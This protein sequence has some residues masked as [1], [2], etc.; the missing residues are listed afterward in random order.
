[1]LLKFTTAAL[2]AIVLLGR[3]GA[4]QTIDEQLQKAIY[5][6]ETAGNLD[7]AI[8][9][10]RQIAASRL[11]SRAVAAEAH[12]RLAKALLDKGDRDGAAREL[13]NLRANFGEYRDVIARLAP[14]LVALEL[15][16]RAQFGTAPDYT[17]YRHTATGTELTHAFG[18]SFLGDSESPDGGH[19]AVFGGHRLSVSVW[20]RPESID[21][22]SLE[23][24][25][26]RDVQLTTFQRQQF[27]GW[28]IRQQTIRAGGGPDRQ[29]ITAIAEY[30]DQ[31]RKMVE[32]L[33]WYRTTKTRVV[34]FTRLPEEDLGEQQPNFSRMVGA[35]VIP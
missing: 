33:T 15:R 8:P 13:Q 3:A 4:G 25:V 18:T 27:E 34:F 30:T 5:A 20:L 26:R 28:N 10:L 11:A 17:H 29:W 14:Q 2:A 21:P 12:Y 22:N 9:I 32:L 16:R 6:Q 24:A 1:M 23:P 31:G 19:I 7:E 35:A